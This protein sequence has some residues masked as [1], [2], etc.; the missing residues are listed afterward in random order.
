MKVLIS[1]IGLVLIFEGLPYAAFP[2][3]M[4]NWLRQLT[5]FPPRILRGIGFAA[6]VCGL[7]LCYLGQRTNLF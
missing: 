3:A 2:E 7:I 1:L 4:Q 6:V 5:T